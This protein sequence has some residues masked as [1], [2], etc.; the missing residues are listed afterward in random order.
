MRRPECRAGPH[1]ASR[2]ASFPVTPATSAQPKSTSERLWLLVVPRDRSVKARAWLA[3]LQSKPSLSLQPN[4]SVGSGC[5][6]PLGALDTAWLKEHKLTSF[7]TLSNVV[8]KKF[9]LEPFCP[10]RE[11][12]TA[13]PC[14]A[15]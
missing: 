2:R 4:D 3:D 1:S 7:S 11:V 14:L 15:L 6:E 8:S 10:K 5:K 9:L 12:S 13:A